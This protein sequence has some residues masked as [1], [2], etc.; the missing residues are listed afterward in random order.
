[1]RRELLRADR[2]LGVAR[3]DLLC[4]AFGYEPLTTPAVRDAAA[5]W[6]DARNTGRPTAADRALDGDVLLAAQARVLATSSDRP[7]VIATTNPAH[8]RR[9]APARVWHRIT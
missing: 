9:Y 6:A 3:L 1:M 8:L 5:L 4:E 2:P 7:V